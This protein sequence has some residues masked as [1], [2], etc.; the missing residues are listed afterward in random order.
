MSEP[1]APSSADDSEPREFEGPDPRTWRGNQEL[2]GLVENILVMDELLSLL[3]GIV[4]QRDTGPARREA[5]EVLSHA[6]YQQR[7]LLA[8]VILDL[9]GV[10]V[11][12]GEQPPP[13]SGGG[14]ARAF[15]A[16]EQKRD[17]LA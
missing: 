8:A 15:G 4:P 17:N 10:P 12:E 7:E 5:I 6:G 13:Y 11:P 16:P 3:K 1:S 9:M 14:R 2:W